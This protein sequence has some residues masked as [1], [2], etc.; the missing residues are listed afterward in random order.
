MIAPDQ[1]L[2]RPPAPLPYLAEAAAAQADKELPA[3]AGPRKAMPQHVLE[4]LQYAAH[5]FQRAQRAIDAEIAA[6]A[7]AGGFM[8]PSHVMRATGCLALLA[9][10]AQLIAIQRRTA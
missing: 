8:D 9:A 4:E 10:E 7:S 5:L 6:L 1:A 2:L 3:W